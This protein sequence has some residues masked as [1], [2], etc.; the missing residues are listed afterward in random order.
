ML[1]AKPLHGPGLT[2]RRIRV[3]D[4]DVVWLR[5]ILEGYEG[6]ATLYGDGSGVVTL[7]TTAAQSSEL[8]ALIEDLR[9]E[10]GILLLGRD[11]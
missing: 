11:T 1:P 6:L 10:A 5:S 2:R 7:S 3:A 9:A 4:S 8:D